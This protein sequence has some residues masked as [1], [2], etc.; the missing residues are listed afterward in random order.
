MLEHWEK[1]WNENLP[2]SFSASVVSCSMVKPLLVVDENCQLS[3]SATWS[4]VP[5]GGFVKKLTFCRE[6]MKTT[7]ETISFPSLQT[8]C[9]INVQLQARPAGGAA[10][11]LGGW[12]ACCTKEWRPRRWAS[13]RCWRWPPRAGNES[14]CGNSRR[15]YFRMFPAPSPLK[16][17]QSRLITS[18]LKQ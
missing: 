4:H 9:S 17:V 11:P 8:N 12:W 2:N 13:G 16:E 14:A 7:S 6:T 10:L 3:T 1:L 15:R 18:H 5:T